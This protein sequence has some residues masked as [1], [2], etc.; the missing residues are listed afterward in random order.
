MR[1]ETGDLQTSAEGCLPEFF[2]AHRPIADSDRDSD[3]RDSQ[4]QKYVPAALDRAFSGIFFVCAFVG[5]FRGFPFPSSSFFVLCPVCCGLWLGAR[6][7]RSGLWP[8]AVGS[9]VCSGKARRSGC[10][11]AACGQRGVC[12]AACLGPLSFGLR[13]ASPRFRFK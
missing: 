1:G 9:K 2:R 12:G 8:A 5:D 11:P 6:T 4:A 10:G 7:R 3:S 13:S